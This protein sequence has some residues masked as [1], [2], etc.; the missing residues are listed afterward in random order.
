MHSLS[1]YLMRCFNPQLQGN[2]IEDRYTILDKVGQFDTYVLIKEYIE[3]KSVGYHLVEK[4][5]QV[6]CFEGMEFDVENRLICGW[7]QVGH[8]GTKSDIINISTGKVDFIKAQDNADI[9][10]H[11]IYFFLPKGF[12]EGIAFFHSYRGNGIKTLF[13]ELFKDYFL[14][15]T[16]LNLQM[17][18]LTYDKAL[19]AWENANAKEIRLIKFSALND[20]ADQ[21]KKLGHNE[22]ELKIKPR[23]KST[24]GKLK[25]Y[26]NQESEQA[27]AIELLSPL[28]SE[29]K[30]VVELNGNKRTFI[31][32]K[33]AS[34]SIC[35]IEAPED[36]ELIDGNPKF[37]AIKKWCDIVTEEFSSTMY[38]GLGKCNEQ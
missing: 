30:T 20:I 3:S 34:N 17:N 27:K 6:F 37:D 23:R 18:P 35:E 31:V 25:D 7:F 11:F 19:A 14:S 21:I 16:K 5:K 28:C 36:L 26:F 29:I 15:K 33:S 38:P 1:P 9:I 32:G 2:K 13:F 4:S 24:F 10:K 12:N 22:Q 8:Y